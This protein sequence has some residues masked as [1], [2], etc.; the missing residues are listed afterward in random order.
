MGFRAQG[1]GLRFRHW[2]LGVTAEVSQSKFGARV[3]GVR[4]R[5]QR[6]GLSV[7]DY[8]EGFRDYGPGSRIWSSEFMIQDLGFRV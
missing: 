8:G 3:L 4:F 1:D 7:Q 2:G 6:L 5:L